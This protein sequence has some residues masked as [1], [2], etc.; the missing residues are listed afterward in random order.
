MLC[1][2]IV[3]SIFQYA[4]VSKSAD[5]NLEPMETRQ[6]VRFRIHGVMTER[7]SLPNALEPLLSLVLRLCLI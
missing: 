6:R 2:R 1:A 5:I 7:L 3:N 4:V